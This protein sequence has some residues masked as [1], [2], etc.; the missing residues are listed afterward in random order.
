MFDKKI[1]NTCKCSS[2]LGKKYNFKPRSLK[3]F[4]IP[5]NTC[6]SPFRFF[7]FNMRMFFRC[8]EKRLCIAECALIQKQVLEIFSFS[9]RISSSFHHITALIPQ[10]NHK[11]RYISISMD[12]STF[13]TFFFRIFSDDNRTKK[14]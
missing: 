12:T 9:S 3:N 13:S 4:V 5:T 10:K 7:Y 6:F 8:F 14:K 2:N 1:H 11:I